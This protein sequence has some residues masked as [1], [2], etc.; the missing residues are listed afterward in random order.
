MKTYLIIY[1]GK[2]NV[3]AFPYKERKRF[4]ARIASLMANL[5]A[6]ITRVYEDEYLDSEEEIELE[7]AVIEKI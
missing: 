4:E 2:E 1:K 7:M 5:E 3:I 6:K